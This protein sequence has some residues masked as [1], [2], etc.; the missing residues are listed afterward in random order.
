M[1]IN[2]IDKEIDKLKDCK[3]VDKDYL[4]LEHKR[5]K[6]NK[7]LIDTT[8]SNV[9]S[10][11]N[12]ILCQCIKRFLEKRLSKYNIR[13]TETINEYDRFEFSISI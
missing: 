12:K 8:I 11:D 6:D 9:K 5:I 3:L 13:V 10:N 1:T 7:I 2:D 4:L